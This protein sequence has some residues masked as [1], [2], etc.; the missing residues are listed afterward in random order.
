[1]TWFSNRAEF[2]GDA[3]AF[4]SPISIPIAAS[5]ASAA[6]ANRLT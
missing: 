3:F 2:E 5:D 6:T 4:I 1:M